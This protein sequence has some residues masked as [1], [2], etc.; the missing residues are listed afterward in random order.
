MFWLLFKDSFSNL[1]SPSHYSPHPN[2]F[3]FK[4]KLVCVFVCV[5]VCVCMILL[6][7]EVSLGYTITIL[8]PFA[9][10]PLRVL[11][12][13][14]LQVQAWNTAYLILVIPLWIRWNTLWAR[15]C[16]HTEL[17]SHSEMTPLPLD[18]VRTWR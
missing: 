10:L 5:C 15:N 13:C 8:W 11:I 16:L 18:R 2:Q 12:P 3:L 1:F 17:S 4:E 6:K 14:F 7:N 9:I